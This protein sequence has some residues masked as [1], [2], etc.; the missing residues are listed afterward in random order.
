MTKIMAVSEAVAKIKDGDVVLAGGFYGN[1]TPVAVVDE[2]LRQGK[3][4]LTLVNNDGNTT[5]KGLGR[6]IAAG[7][8]KKFICTWC[9]RLPLAAE[10]SDAGRLELELCPQ[11]TFAERI[12]A[13]GFGLGGVLTPTGLD[14]MVEE[15][16]GQRVHL[17]GRD[18]LYHPPPWGRCCHCGG[19]PRRRNRQ[20]SIPPYP[21]GLF[22]GYVLR[23][24]AGNSRNYRN[25]RAGRQHKPRACGRT[26]RGGGYFGTGRGGGVSVNTGMGAK[27]KIARRVAA[28]FKD[29]DLVNLGAGI[30]GMAAQ[31]MDRGQVIYMQTENGIVGAGPNNPDLPYDPF[32]TDASENP[33]TI[34]PG[35]AIVESCTS[36]G[37]IR[38]GHLAATV[39]GT[40][41]VDAEGSIANW[42]V[43]G[44]KLVGMGGA[45]DLV[46]GARRVIVATEHCDKKGNSKILEKC[47]F[48]LTGSK[49]V[50]RIITELT[51]FDIT[52]Q[53]FVLREIAEE[54]TVDEI[55][56]KTS[57]QFAV[58]PNLATITYGK[59]GI[60]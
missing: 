53:G 7:Q 47:T 19:S 34:L 20:F 13:A 46:S 33:V 24:Q 41:Q 42:I 10:L 11:G 12:R 21:T 4:D 9:G 54:I 58:A 25:H 44:G 23:R 56:E 60:S 29:G 1:G 14:T 32:R 57:A 38:G 3:K 26:R 28:E 37:I 27:E 40:L 15:K 18:W 2:M 22:G 48:P 45:M 6:L 59:E 50:N 16:W 51:V 30:P 55:R 8:A 49:C 5:E 52:T 17:N 39:L 35:G 36:F 31:Y 43:P